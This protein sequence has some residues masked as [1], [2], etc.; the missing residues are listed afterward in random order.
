MSSGVMLLS[1]PSRK[2]T[3]GA[4]AAA[5]KSNP[6]YNALICPW[7]R[8]RILK[9]FHPFSVLMNLKSLAIFLQAP[10]IPSEST[11]VRTSWPTI[12]KGNFDDFNSSQ[13]E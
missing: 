1:H 9:P 10:S 3:L 13:T 2:I 6:S 8:W 7:L 4:E 11:L 5:L 12:S